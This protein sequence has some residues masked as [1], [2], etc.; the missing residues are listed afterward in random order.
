MKCVEK[1]AQVAKDLNSQ[2]R[3]EKMGIW[4]DRKSGNKKTM[5][6]ELKVIQI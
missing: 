1:E 2:K 5:L 3:S 4:E 6:S